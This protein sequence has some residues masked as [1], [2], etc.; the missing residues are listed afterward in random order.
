MA[1]SMS[2]RWCVEV[3]S[4]NGQTH[5]FDTPTKDTFC[6]EIAFAHGA[7]DLRNFASGLCFNDK[8]KIMDSRYSEHMI[9]VS[10]PFVY[11]QIFKSYRVAVNV[12]LFNEP[13]AHFDAVAAFVATHFPTVQIQQRNDMAGGLRVQNTHGFVLTGD[14]FV[15]PAFFWATA[16]YRDGTIDAN[17]FRMPERYPSYYPKIMLFTSLGP[18][19]INEYGYMQNHQKRLEIAIA[20]IDSHGGIAN[21]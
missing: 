3:E 14:E 5:T 16:L 10:P 15:A 17:G 2:T 6:R 7:Q 13:M 12:Q 9:H 20:C 11:M 21:A 8:T 1:N 19:Y 4:H 18:M